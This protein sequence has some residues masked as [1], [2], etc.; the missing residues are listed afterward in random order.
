MK[1]AAKLDRTL[2]ALADPNRRRVVELLREQPHTAGELATEVGMTPAALTRHLKTL[3]SAG[4]V[5]ESHPEYDA[6]VR[7]YNLIPAPMADLKDWLTKTEAL[8][9][10]Q[11]AA[12]KAHVE[13][14]R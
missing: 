3:K 11:L 2:L 1:Q 6:R 7:V 9:A 14:R 12:F 8:W 4:L 5:E 10:R 13:G